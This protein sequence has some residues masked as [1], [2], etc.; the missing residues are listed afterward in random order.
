MP[1]TTMPRPKRTMPVPLDK[2]VTTSLRM[3][4]EVY[5]DLMRVAEREDR[6]LNAQ[7]VRAL[8]EWLQTQP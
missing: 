3:P 7:I 8:K 5:N 2:P 6:T 1:M 4:G